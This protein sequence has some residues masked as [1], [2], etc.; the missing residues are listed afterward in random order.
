MGVVFGHCEWEASWGRV[1]E[2]VDFA[3]AP[4]V[5]RSTLSDPNHPNIDAFEV[6]ADAWSGRAMMIMRRL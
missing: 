2:R 4:F 1:R 3:H 5:N 6:N